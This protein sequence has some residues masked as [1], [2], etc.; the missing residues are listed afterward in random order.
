MSRQTDIDPKY[1]AD[2]TSVPE[3]L[4]CWVSKSLASQAQPTHLS[5]VVWSAI[6]VLVFFVGKTRTVCCRK[7]SHLRACIPGMPQLWD[8]RDGSPS[9]IG[10]IERFHQGHIICCRAWIARNDQKLKE[11]CAEAC[12]S[13]GSLP[14]NS[15]QCLILAVSLPRT[16]TVM[17]LP[18]SA[19]ISKISVAFPATGKISR[20]AIFWMIFSGV[21]IV[22]SVHVFKEWQKPRNPLFLQDS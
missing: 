8:S 9:L 17:Y 3:T 22:E 19:C 7:M 14:H 1:E 21:T 18:K 11:S 2:L 20:T 12:A 16:T 6:F 5:G 10:W 15:E 4:S 13:F